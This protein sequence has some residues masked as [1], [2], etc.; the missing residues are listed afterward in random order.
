MSDNRSL[1]YIKL[2]GHDD[3]QFI[4]SETSS[5]TMPDL[6]TIEPHRHDYQTVIWTQSGTGEHLV[7]GQ[8]VQLT[9]SSFCMIARGQIHQFIGADTDFSLT[10]IRF[11]DAFLPETTRGQVWS[12][13]AELFNNQASLRRALSASTDE[14]DEIESLLVLMKAEYRRTNML[15]RDDALR[16]LLQFLLLKIAR[17]QQRQAG[18]M[19][20]VSVADYGLYRAF[21]SVLED[22]FAEQHSVQYYAESMNSASSKLSELT[23]KVLG[24]TAKEVIQDR[25]TL[26]AKRL[27]RFSNLSVK[28]IAFALGYDTPDHFSRAFKRRTKVP[29]NEYRKHNEKIT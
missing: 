5:A 25:I 20:T 2:P 23:K 7:D 28:E 19:A 10:A 26:E 1:P 27:L 9:P 17:L 22:H 14:I 12:Y 13:R 6:A 24:K 21:V 15:R 4:I 29:P 18:E 3:P 8:V 16:S 11:N